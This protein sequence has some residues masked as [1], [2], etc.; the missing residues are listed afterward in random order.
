MKKIFLSIMVSASLASS[1]IGCGNTV[2][3]QTNAI[4]EMIESNDFNQETNAE[5]KLGGVIFPVPSNWE[6]LSSDETTISL[7]KWVNNSDGM[8]INIHLLDNYVDISST[9]NQNT[10]ITSVGEGWMNY[11]YSNMSDIVIAGNKGFSFDFSGIE[12]ESGNQLDGRCAMMFQKNTNNGYMVLMMQTHNR[13]INYVDDFNKIISNA[14]ISSDSETSS[15][16]SFSD[17]NNSSAAKYDFTNYST[18][19]YTDILSGEYNGQTVCLEGIVDNISI[20]EPTVGLD[21]GGSSSFGTWIPYGESYY[22]QWSNYISDVW[23]DSPVSTALNLKNGD[24]VRGIITIF[25]DGSFSFSNAKALE[26]IGTANLNDIYSNYQN[27]CTDLEYENLLRNPE[28]YKNSI[29]KVSG[30]IIQ[31]IDE[32]NYLLSTDSGNVYIYYA[33]NEENRE[34]RLLEND[35]VTVCGRFDD[36]K[37]Y[38]VAIGGQKTVPELSAY[39]IVLNQ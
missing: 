1:L 26:I 13:S 35:N 29:Y 31:I 30:T 24:I 2:T 15:T 19:T 28:N 34:Y 39:I 22:Y 7:Q 20:R 10:L 9:E 25:D 23:D 16:T 21:L 4:Q 5:L 3:N 6:I 11:Q 17:T 32:D 27:N 33:K 8:A 38:D 36:L 12:K 18:V 14:F 37:T